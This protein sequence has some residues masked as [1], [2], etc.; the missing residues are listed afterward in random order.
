MGMY[1]YKEF[2]IQ[3]AASYYGGIGIFT[4]S[5]FTERDKWSISSWIPSNID[6]LFQFQVNT[7]LQ[8][9]TYYLV[10]I[11]MKELEW[12]TNMHL[13]LFFLCISTL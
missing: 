11:I 6:K 3:H 13:N 9:N 2:I 4:Y 12:N 1:C 8:P 7:R 5:L 10:Y